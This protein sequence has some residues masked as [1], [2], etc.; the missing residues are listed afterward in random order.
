VPLVARDGRNMGVLQVG[1]KAGG[2]FSQE[3]EDVLIQLAQM[4]SIAI[5]NALFAELREANRLK[6][7]F[8]AT[9]SHELR[10]PLSALRSWVWM[11]RRGRLDADGTAR[12]I[13][14][15]ERNVLA[16]SRIV[17]DLLDV[18]RVVTGKLRLRARPVEFRSVVD[19]AVDAIMPAAAAKGIDV[20]RGIEGE[21]VPVLGDADRLQQVV[22]NLLSN[23]IKFTSGGGRVEIEIERTGQEVSI[24]VHDTGKGI[25]P[26]F[27]PHVFDRFRQ[28]DASASRSSGGL[29]LG[30]SI[31]RH[32]VELHG[33]RVEARSAGEGQ[34]AT[35]TVVLPL[36]RTTAGVPAAVA[37]TAEAPGISGVTILL[38]ED[39]PDTREAIA[40]LLV[41]AGAAVTATGSAG[42]ALEVLAGAAPDVILCDIGLPGDDGHVL[43]QKI[44][45]TGC[46][47]PAI[48]VTAYAQTQDREHA[49]AAGFVEHVA[50]PASPDDL[51]AAVARVTDDALLRRLPPPVG[52]VEA[53]AAAPTAVAASGDV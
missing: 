41:G 32:L 38:V 30:L 16:Q 36:F 26:S 23:A 3:E 29:G 14:A 34:G 48:A 46:D 45:A 27:L 7:E 39:D 50:K 37:A 5:E 6:D 42:Q 21:A 40:A 20:V 4:T 43:L 49:L 2:E 18:S 9:V 25:S 52:A 12:A 31:V 53:A 22:W 8:L 47:A 33:G 51:I 1:D 19:A 10:T 11:L 15:I 17:D 13:D 35:F 24:A 28:A 44:R